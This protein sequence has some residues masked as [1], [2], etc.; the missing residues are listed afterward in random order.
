[1][2][3]LLSICFLITAIVATVSITTGQRRGS[4]AA[5]NGA[6]R[7]AA[8]APTA[9]NNADWPTFGGDNTRTCLPR[10]ADVAAEVRRYGLSEKITS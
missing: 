9:G 7:G 5:D 2:K 3:E 4:Q 1:M 10:K 6:P 8:A